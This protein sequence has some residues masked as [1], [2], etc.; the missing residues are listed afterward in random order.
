VEPS[1]RL[2]PITTWYEMFVET[3]VT[4]VE[5]DVFWYES[6]EAGFAYFFRWLGVPR[7]TV[8]VVW[9]EQ[10]PLHIECRTFGDQLVS[11]GDADPILAEVTMLFRAAGLLRGHAT[12]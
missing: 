3:R 7:A 2:T 12:H 4:G 1:D 8:L 9:N 6:V 5:F 10:G 11:A